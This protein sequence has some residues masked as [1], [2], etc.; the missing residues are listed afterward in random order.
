MKKGEYWD[1]QRVTRV[2]NEFRYETELGRGNSFETIAAYG[3]NG[4]KPHYETSNSTN[5]PI[6]TTS[7]LVLDSGG[8]YLDGTTDVTRTLHFGTPTE[9]Q[10]L[11][12]TRVLMGCIDLS[13]LIF[14]AHLQISAADVVARAPLWQVGLDYMH[15]TG[16]GVGAFLSVHECKFYPGF[17]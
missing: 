16:H 6:N 17:R 5:I 3:A 13:M 2:V 9:E 8:Q 4:A 1:E 12:Y 11:A 14:P 7:T 15:G 10:K